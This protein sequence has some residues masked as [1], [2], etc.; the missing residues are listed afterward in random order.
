MRK[1]K[2]FKEKNKE[3]LINAKLSFFVTKSFK[4]I[5]QLRYLVNS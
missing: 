5:S 1:S 2:L 3:N 4:E